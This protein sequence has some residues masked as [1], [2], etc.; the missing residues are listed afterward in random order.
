MLEKDL[1]QLISRLADANANH[2]YPCKGIL[3]GNPFLEQELDKRRYPFEPSL[4]EKAE[5]WNVCLLSTTQLLKAA[6]SALNNEQKAEKFKNKL[7]N[8]VGVFEWE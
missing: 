3:I 5:P 2:N 6:V 7:L 4:V 1:N 8:T